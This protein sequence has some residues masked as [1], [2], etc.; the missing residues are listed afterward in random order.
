MTN[1]EIENI[2][3][4][5]EGTRIEFKKCDDG[6]VPRSIYDTICSFL[7]KE[8]GVILAGVMIMERLMVYQKIN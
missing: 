6:K 3:S 8:G 4:K 2:L 1:Q 7:N 5:G